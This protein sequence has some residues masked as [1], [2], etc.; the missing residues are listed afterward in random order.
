MTIMTNNAPNELII[1]DDKDLL[2]KLKKVWKILK[3]EKYILLKR[4][5]KK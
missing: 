4:H 3:M 1:K 2:S 5:L